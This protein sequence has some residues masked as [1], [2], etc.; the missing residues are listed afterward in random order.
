MWDKI[1]NLQVL[2][3]MEKCL[4]EQQEECRQPILCDTKM[5]I[6]VVDIFDKYNMSRAR[7]LQPGS[8]KYN[9]LVITILLYFFA[10]DSLASYKMPRMYRKKIAEL[11]GCDPTF[12]SHKKNLI[13]FLH[14]KDK[15]FREETDKAIDYIQ[16]ELDRCLA[17]S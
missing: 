3:D 11:I 16:G 4:R 7:P 13:L 12:I 6:K 2:R 9:F 10:P 15:V 17:T 8:S 1:T 14:M 5:M